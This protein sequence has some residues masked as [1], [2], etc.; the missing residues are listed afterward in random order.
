MANSSGDTNTTGQIA[1]RVILKMTEWEIPLTPENYKVWFEYF[2]GSDEGL[3]AHLDEMIVTGKA[4]DRETN[5]HLYEKYFGKEKDNKLMEEI[6]SESQKILKN[7]LEEILTTNSF[8]SDYRN[9]LKGYY[10]KL[11][12][13]KGPSQIKEIVGG[14]VKDTQVMAESST[15]L[16]KSLEEATSHTENLRRRLE[17]TEKESLID[18]LT[19]LHNRKAFD[20]KLKDLYAEYVESGTNF[21]VVM[22]DIDFFK[23]FNDR[24]GHKIGDEVLRKVGTTLY[25]SLKGRDFPARYGGEEFIV[26]LP[27]TILDNT[28]IVAEQIR[29][30]LSE[31]RVKLVKTGKDLGNITVSLGVSEIRSG[32]SIDTVVER[33]DKALY[34]AKDSG[35]N[36]FKSEKDLNSP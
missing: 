10:R 19:G 29:E 6:Q 3:T 9:K 1:K 32:D 12:G 16:E 8:T 21:S 27:N 5:S 18:A 13:A 24:Y 33:A 22:L 26:L 14:I 30:Q 31:K 28:C 25:E 4:F 15:R 35:R 23:K 11:E 34:L 17:K 2:V 20:R 36:N 7:I